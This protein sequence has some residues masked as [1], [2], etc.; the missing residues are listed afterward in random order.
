VRFL[1]GTPIRLREARTSCLSRKPIAGFAGE[2]RRR[3]AE[4][5][6]AI[7]AQGRRPLAAWMDRATARS[8]APIGSSGACDRAIARSISAKRCPVQLS[9]SAL[10]VTSAS[11]L[12]CAERPHER[13][14]RE[15]S[16][17]L[18]LSVLPVI[19]FSFFRGEPTHPPARAIHL[20]ATRA[21]NC[22]TGMLPARRALRRRRQ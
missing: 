12:Y 7:A 16:V 17:A 20:V 2:Q 19:G 18:C 22:F 21:P 3:R 10:S 4:I 9:L 5:A 8:Q 14:Q 11:G 6:E 13:A 1:P 15:S